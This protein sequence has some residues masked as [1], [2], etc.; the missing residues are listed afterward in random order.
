VTADEATELADYFNVRILE[1][2]AKDCKNVEKA[3]IMMAR[4]IK[5]RIAIAQLKKPVPE[6]GGSSVDTTLKNTGQSKKL[7]DNKKGRCS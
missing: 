2:S 7:Q 6:S 1:T 4:E 3:F 5:S